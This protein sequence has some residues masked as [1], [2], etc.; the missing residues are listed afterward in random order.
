MQAY[1]GVAATLSVGLRC[2]MYYKVGRMDQKI[3]DKLD[4]LGMRFDKKLDTF[5]EEPQYSLRHMRSQMSN[6][7]S[8]VAS[9]HARLS[10]DVPNSLTSDGE[11]SA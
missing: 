2:G 4:K 8:L 9:I 3:D 6:T 7:H 10:N 5:A 1:V 11:R